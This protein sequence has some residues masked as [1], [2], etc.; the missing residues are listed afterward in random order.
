[1]KKK[2]SRSWFDRITPEKNRAV[3]YGVTDRSKDSFLVSLNEWVI[4]NSPVKDKEKELMYSSLE[5]LVRSAGSDDKTARSQV[6]RVC[7]PAQR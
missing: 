3:V 4:D 6:H 2:S 1:M 7:P 5:L